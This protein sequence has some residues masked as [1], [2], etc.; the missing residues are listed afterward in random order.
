MPKIKKVALVGGGTGGHVS[1]LLAVAKQLN[2]RNFKHIYIGSGALL[3]DEILK[4]EK[5]TYYKIS[6]GKFRRESSFVA[7]LNNFLDVFKVIFGVG[8]AFFI[9]TSF[10][11]DLIFSKSGYVSVPVAIAA[12]L[13][14]IPFVTHESDTIPGIAT[15]FCSK[16]AHA[17][18][19]AFEP[20]MY[21]HSIR[22]KAIFTGLPISEAYEESSSAKEDYI[23]ITGGS[24][25]AKELN[26]RLAEVF[27]ELLKS[28]KIIHLTG[29]ENL[30]EYLE[31]KKTL[32]NGLAKNYE[33]KGFSK[34]MP[35]LM[36][37]AKLVISRSGATT[38]FEIASLN[39]KVLLMPI[40]SGVADHQIMNAQSMASLAGVDIVF[41]DDSGKEILKKINKLISVRSVETNAIYLP[42]S[43]ELIARLIDDFIDYFQ[44]TRLKKVFMIGIGGV[45]M[46][47]IANI[48]D[49]MKISVKGSDIKTGGHSASN[50]N[51]GYDLVVYSSAADQNSPAKI[52]HDK[53]ARLGIKTIKRSELVGKLMSGFRGIS[54]SGMHGKTT[55]SSIIS[56]ALDRY[57]YDPSYL[58]GAPQ[59][60]DVK[61][62]KLG[63]GIDFVAEACEYDGSFLDFNTKI[64]VI[65]NIEKEHLDYFTGGIKQIIDEFV[66]FCDNIYPGGL[67]VYCCDDDNVKE[68]VKMAGKSLAEKRVK[69]ISYGFSEKSDIAISSY[70]VEKGYASFKIHD[71]IIQTPQVGEH[72]ALNT[73][74][75]LAVCDYLGVDRFIFSLYLAQFSGASRR[76]E[77]IGRKDSVEVYD[78]YG[79]HPTEIDKTLIGFAQKFP[80][81]RKIVIFEPHQQKRFND[82][83]NDYKEVFA[84]VSV[85]IVGILPVYRVPGRDES[86]KNTAED[87]VN[88][89]NSP[90][91][92]YL[93]SYE[94][95]ENFLVEN[96]KKADVV[97][98]MGATDVYK[99][100]KKFLRD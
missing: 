41:P 83:F 93:D 67:L 57:G 10:K 78:D 54:V 33:V 96:V 79:H 81:R 6:C 95:A 77:Y 63:R 46:R 80:D 29:L 60:K 16:F 59:S 50:I 31:F 26:E 45:S 47:G 70:K 20:R 11:P 8:Q 98:T 91:I 24:S 17:I 69:L 85:D 30:S 35:S 15:K 34:N 49:K 5:I 4:N 38:I 73:A 40:T 58:I 87:L 62:S 7:F 52:E 39:K 88:Q 97:L 55:V 32:P 65:T 3:E 68:V 27:C 51:I 48:F 36:R 9:L 99:I 71:Q 66:K 2:I 92:I 100:G 86:I 82:F 12:W 1:P 44:L 74:A 14:K 76:L 43:A 75:S 37:H 42:K 23:L 89:I 72:F 64:A 84:K 90:R 56:Y 61:S 53:A 13:L 18:F 94:T 21:P 19:T 22:K 25:G 28:H